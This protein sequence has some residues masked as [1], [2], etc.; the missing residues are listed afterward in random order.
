MFNDGLESV[1]S[2]RNVIY[3][4]QRFKVDDQISDEMVGTERQVF[5][6]IYVVGESREQL[7]ETAEFIHSNLEIYD[8][9]HTSMI[10]DRYYPS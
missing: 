4:I 1:E 2:H 5:A 8:E 9:N 3:I 6:R 7:R 10:V